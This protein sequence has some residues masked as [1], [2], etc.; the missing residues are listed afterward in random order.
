MVPSQHERNIYTYSLMIFVFFSLLWGNGSKIIDEN[1]LRRPHQI[2]FISHSTKVKT[3]TI[4]TCTSSASSYLL[5]FRFHTFWFP[6][7]LLFIYFA[8]ENPF[9]SKE[10]RTDLRWNFGLFLLM[11]LRSFSFFLKNY[12]L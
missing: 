2:S 11:K 12:F 9:I 7:H 10:F 6:S 8:F 3:K 1:N 4:D 5:F